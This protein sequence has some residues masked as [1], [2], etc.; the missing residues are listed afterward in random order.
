MP[1]DPR[2]GSQKGKVKSGTAAAT[3]S[4]CGVPTTRTGHL[5]PG[6]GM[7]PSLTNTAERV[8]SFVRMMK[9]HSAGSRPHAANEFRVEKRA[10]GTA[11]PFKGKTTALSSAAP[12]VVCS[13]R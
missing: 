9:G 10:I 8:H 1:G 2:C 7:G 12:A 3:H 13:S 11:S 4:K 5:P 6:G